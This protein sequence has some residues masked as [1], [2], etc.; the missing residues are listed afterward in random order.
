M[1]SILLTVFLITP[2]FIFAQSNPI[3]FNLKSGV[4]LF[5]EWSA[6]APA[7]TYPQSMMF[8]TSRRSDPK[9]SDEPNGDWVSPYNLKSRA[10]FNGLGDLGF[11]F[12]STSAVQEGD[13]YPNAAILA[14]DT[15]GC[16]EIYVRWTARTYKTGERNYFLQLQY[17][18][19]TNSQFTNINEAVY[20][21]STNEGDYKI[22]DP[23]KLPDECAN[24]PYIQLR[25]KYCYANDGSTGSRPQLAVDDII[26]AND[27]NSSIN[28]NYDYYNTLL[29]RD[30]KIWLSEQNVNEIFIY[31]AIG[32]I[33]Y[34]KINSFNGFL[35]MEFLP[36]GLYFLVLKTNDNFKTYKIILN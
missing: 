10:R 31:N 8:H 5:L 1:K 7:R 6:D 13:N 33:V 22:F 18:A 23:I 25:W 2:I 28:S 19:D 14:L 21:S 36:S 29:V 27:I 32:H 9:L 11:S 26:V 24:K 20:Y 30:R 12:L 34:H 3:S 16:S 35:N 15:R 4:Y 17:R